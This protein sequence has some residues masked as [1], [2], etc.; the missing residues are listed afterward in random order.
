MK[1]AAFIIFLFVSTVSFA[2]TSARWENIYGGGGSEYGYRVRT[3]LD[4]GYIVA[5]STSSTGISDGYLV[6]VDSLGLVMWS[7]YYRGNNVDVFR[8]IKQLPDSG[9]IICG[10]S[11]SDSTHGGYDGWVVRTDK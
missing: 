3:C 6:R 5:G 8:S 2:Q 10:F 7:K 4:Q 9:Y 11:N 1:K